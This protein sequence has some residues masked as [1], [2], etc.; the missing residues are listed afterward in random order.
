MPTLRRLFRASPNWLF[1][2]PS[3]AMLALFALPLAAL[4]QRAAR[5]AFLIYALSPSALA[6]LRLSLI[7]SLLTVLI[8]IL[9]GTPLAYMFARWNFPL[10]Q[11][12]EMLVDLPVVL[13]PSVAGLS[14]LIAFGRQ[15]LFGKTLAALDISLP[16]TTAAVIYITDE[17]KHSPAVPEKPAWTSRRSPD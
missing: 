17:S 5:E 3:V 8:T 11:A 9:L 2:L 10:K 15:G 4:V 1:V 16:F 6:A 7:T 12:V 14:L 13:P